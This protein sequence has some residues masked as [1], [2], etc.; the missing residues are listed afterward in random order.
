MRINAALYMM[1]TQTFQYMHSS[2]HILALNNPYSWK[3]YRI[4][5]MS[6]C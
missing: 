2:V 6:E 4:P 5:E 1:M 3:S